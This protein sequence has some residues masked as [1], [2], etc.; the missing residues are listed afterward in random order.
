VRRD[1]AASVVAAALA[2]GGGWLDPAETADVLASYGLPVLRGRPAASA[3]DAAAA[4]RALGG[5]V[6]LKAVVPGLV[7]KSDAGAVRLDLRGPD[8]VG[9]AAQD[10]LR[11]LSAA[12]HRDV[13]FLVQP[14]AEPGVEMIV[15]VVQDPQFGPVVACGL[16][17]TMVEVLA[18]VSVRLAPLGRR[19]AA[20]MIDALEGRALLGAFRG[21]PPADVAALEDA[22][23]RV[24]ALV[25]DLPA[26]AELDCNPIV[27]HERGA[28]VVDARIR[29]ADPAPR[30]PPGARRFA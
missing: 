9:A 24:G 15:G 16:G 2:R 29:V 20:E 1:G 19:D 11:H 7:H 10:L 5:R 3:E 21:R 17:G 22:I 28:S 13:S 18:D 30:L 27:I 23:L 12:G 8:E 14:M 25:E 4:A 6:A 26:I